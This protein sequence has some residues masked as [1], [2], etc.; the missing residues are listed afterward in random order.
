MARTRSVDRLLNY[1][2]VRNRL[3]N[4]RS[5]LLLGNG[6]SIA[7]DP[8]FSYPSLYDKAVAAG[9]SP[10][11]QKVFARLGTNNFEGVMRLLADSHWVARTYGLIDRDRS[12]MLEDL[13]VV[14]SALVEAIAR[15]HLDHTG[16]VSDDKKQAAAEFI[17]PYHNVFTT[18][19]DL[20]LYWVVMHGDGEPTYRDGFG[21]DPSEPD[22]PFVVF[23]F[24]LGE[25]EGVFYLH[26]GL[27]LYV[28]AG[29][30]CKHCWSRTGERLTS[31]IR[32]G[33]ASGQYPLFVAEGLPKKKLEQVLRSAYLSYAIDKFERVKNR[34]VVFGHSLGDNDDH[35]RQAIAGNRNLKELYVGVHRGD[36]ASAETIRSS[37]AVIQRVRR[38]RGL[39]PL[40]VQ[41]YRSSTANVWG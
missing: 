24:H 31:L 7:C 1:A 17:K 29:Q 36:R 38:Q 16:C 13:E 41:Y 6:F 5:H 2:T 20:L 3:G 18:N 32:S 9:L 40:D 30:V 21:D 28:D 35:V 11:A 10:R 26:G 12:L 33:L 22:A 19:Y 37:V 27:H 39:A 25:Q 8:V 23:S 34:L 15:S 14:K 4:G